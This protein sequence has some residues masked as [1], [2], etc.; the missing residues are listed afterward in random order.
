MSYSKAMEAVL[1][2]F[3]LGVRLTREKPIRPCITNGEGMPALMYSLKGI[4]G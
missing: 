3:G 4:P 2:M 1:K